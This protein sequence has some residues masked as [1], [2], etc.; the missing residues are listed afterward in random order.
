MKEMYVFHVSEV[1]VRVKVEV[2]ISIPRLE[3]LKML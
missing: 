2:L 1:V 3:F